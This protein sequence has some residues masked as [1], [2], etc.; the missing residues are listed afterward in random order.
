MRHFVT[1]S[2][3]IHSFLYSRLTSEASCSLVSMDILKL[4]A[5]LLDQRILLHDN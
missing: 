2:R 3:F 4:F 1:R 5:D